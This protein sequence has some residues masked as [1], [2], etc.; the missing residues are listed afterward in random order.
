MFFPPLVGIARQPRDFPYVVG[1]P[2]ALGSSISREH[3]LGRDADIIHIERSPLHIFDVPEEMSMAAGEFVLVVL[4]ERFTP[5]DA[6]SSRQHIFENR[7][8]LIRP[9][10]VDEHPQTA[11]FGQAFHRLPNHR[12]DHRQVLIGRQLVGLRPVPVIDPDIV[13]RINENSLRDSFGE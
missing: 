13:R 4:P 1:Y 10:F 11:S 12:L 7:S 9:R 8:D 2:G 5:D 6:V 3:P